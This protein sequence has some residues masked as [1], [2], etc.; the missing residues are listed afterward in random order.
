MSEHAYEDV[1]VPARYRPLLRRLQRGTYTR[2]ELDWILHIP[3]HL[4]VACVTAH[5]KPPDVR[6]WRLRNQSAVGTRPPSTSTPH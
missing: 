6:I 1:K 4:V 3:S 5:R 2:D